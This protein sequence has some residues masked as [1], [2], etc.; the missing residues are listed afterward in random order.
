MSLDA[1][2]TNGPAD[3]LAGWRSQGSDSAAPQV[4]FTHPINDGADMARAVETEQVLIPEVGHLQMMK[5]PQRLA[6]LLGQH[7]TLTESR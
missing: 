7:F 1:V 3:S 4:I 5:S 2:R 6:Q